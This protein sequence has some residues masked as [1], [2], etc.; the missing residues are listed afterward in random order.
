MATNTGDN[1]RDGSVK[2]RTQVHNP[3]TD[4]WVKRNTKTG[5]FIN[6]KSDGKPHKGVPKEVDK[7]RK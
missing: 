7:R 3:K 1:H 4:N 5:Q 6:Q 2:E